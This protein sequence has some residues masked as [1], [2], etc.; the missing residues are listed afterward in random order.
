LHTTKEKITLR[1]L[2]DRD[3]ILHLRI[4]FS[5][6]L[7][8][9]FC[10]GVSQAAVIHLSDTVI[11][12]IA[13][14]LFIYPA[15]NIYNSFMDKDTGSIGGLKNPPPVTRKLYYASII[16]DITG[17]ALCAITGWQNMLVMAGY[18]AFSK[19][20]SWEGI[21]L[22]KYTYLGWF[23]VMFF[24]GGYTFMLANM[25]AQSQV[26]MAWFTGKN[27]ECMAIAS[28]LIGGSY[29][30]TQIYQH[31]EDR[32]RGDYTIS[33]RL[34]II[35]TFVFT[36]VLFTAGAGVAFHYFTRYY[37]LSQFFI[38]LICLSPVIGYF[39]YWF[40]I[41]LKNRDNA[42]YYHAMLMNKV[43]S[44]CMVV[45]FSVILVINHHTQ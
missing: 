29:P 19:A 30:L 43:S 9:V 7:L 37:L 2:F 15:S 27:I 31:E 1:N 12:F 36:A 16:F 24:Q 45:C 3:T 21:R 38:F 13:L 40:L 33:Y 11:V 34:G 23:S 22:K 8:P 14:H 6:F 10:F 4:P 44:F 18:I 20:Y 28:L 39:S 25:A 35:G 17:I 32:S 26:N 42:D 41:T 5:F